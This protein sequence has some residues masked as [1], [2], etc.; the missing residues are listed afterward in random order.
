MTICIFVLLLAGLLIA[1]QKALSTDGA[2]QVVYVHKRQVTGRYVQ[3]R[4]RAKP[5]S[6]QH[7][8]VRTWFQ[9][10]FRMYQATG[11]C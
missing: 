10:S 4:Y 3:E 2:V 11:K 8:D 5:R 6:R 1:A 9:Y 7:A